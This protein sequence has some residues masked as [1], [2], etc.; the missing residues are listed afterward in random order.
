[1]VAVQAQL[2]QMAHLLLAVQ[3]VQEMII[4]VSLGRLQVPHI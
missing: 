3:A 2:V 1:V 4:Q